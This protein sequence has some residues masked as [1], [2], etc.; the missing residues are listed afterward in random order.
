MEGLL[1]SYAWTLSQ[2][3]KLETDCIQQK[4]QDLVHFITIVS[5]S[6]SD[7]FTMSLQSKELD[8]EL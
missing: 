1:L 2:Q 8:V 6:L 3:E 5:G 4:N 7:V